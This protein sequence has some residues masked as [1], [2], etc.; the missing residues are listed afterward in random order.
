MSYIVFKTV[1]G[2]RYLY[3][4]RTYRQGGRVRTES[5]YLGP[6]DGT[7]RSVAGS[8]RQRPGFLKKIGSFIEA[9]RLTPAERT[10]Q[11]DDRAMLKATR[12]QDAARTKMLADLHERYGLKLGPV[13]PTPVEKAPPTITHASLASAPAP[14]AEGPAAEATGPEGLE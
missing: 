2:R 12:A 14:A 11:V 8:P 3:L 1:N 5:R 4:Q 13:N 9:N 7:K 6:V 10:R